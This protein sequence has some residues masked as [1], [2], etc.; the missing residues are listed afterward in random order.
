[1]TEIV[2]EVRGSRRTK[3]SS[4]VAEFEA[5]NEVVDDDAMVNGGG[6]IVRGARLDDGEDLLAAPELLGRRR[7]VRLA[8][9]P[10][11]GDETS[12]L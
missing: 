3:R 8:A 11:G 2:E 10:S 9:E 7:K 5:S 4:A 1:M 12:S 6:R